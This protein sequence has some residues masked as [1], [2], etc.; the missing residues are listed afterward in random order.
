[1]FHTY[2]S[3][4]LSYCVVFVG[5]Y[6]LK[7]SP[8]WN[9]KQSFAMVAHGW[10]RFLLRADVSIMMCALNGTI[11]LPLWSVRKMSVHTNEPSKNK[12][13]INRDG[14]WIRPLIPCW[15]IDVATQLLC[16][17]YNYGCCVNVSRAITKQY[18]SKQNWGTNI[19]ITWPILYSQR[20]GTAV[21]RNRRE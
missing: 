16:S 8:V 7:F 3:F 2:V 19:R 18:L 12:P 1:M 5:I 20:V 10:E 4:F 15:M 9:R 14:R 6:R 13:P 17:L 11:Y 21:R